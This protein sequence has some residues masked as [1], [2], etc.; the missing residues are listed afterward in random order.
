MSHKHQKMDMESLL[1]A[2]EQSIAEDQRGRLDRLRSWSTGRRM[3]VLVGAV[4]TLSIAVVLGTPRADLAVFP[5]TRLVLALALL[6][7]AVGLGIYG[8]MQSI[9]RASQPMRAAVAAGFGF[10][11][12]IALALFPPAHVHHPE[13]LLGVG[14]DFVARARACFFFGMG[15]GLPLLVAG[16]LLARRG[17]RAERVRVALL[18]LGSAVGN[19]TLLFHC[20]LTAVVHRVAGHAAVSAVLLLVALLVLALGRRRNV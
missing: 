19:L 18:V 9:G 16:G 20:P 14:D 5:V 2:T 4:V 1:A 12:P 6:S 17:F 8:A 13:S 11:I 3:W 15:T 10:A 7:V